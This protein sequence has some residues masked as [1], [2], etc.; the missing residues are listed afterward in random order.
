VIKSVGVVAG[1]QAGWLVL[2][3]WCT[4]IH[5]GSMSKWQHDDGRRVGEGVH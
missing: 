1:V 2:V 4:Y 5:A 3:I